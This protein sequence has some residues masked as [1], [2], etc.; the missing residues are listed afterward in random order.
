MHVNMYIILK[1]I[2]VFYVW[3]YLYG[4]ANHIDYKLRLNRIIE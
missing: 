3:I 2:R 1:L 4:N